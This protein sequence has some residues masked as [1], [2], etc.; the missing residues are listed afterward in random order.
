MKKVFVV[1]DH[2][3]M[4]EMLRALILR[5]PD[6]AF[7]GDAE[8]GSEALTK[9]PASSPDVILVDVSLPGM[10]G[11]EL[12]EQL[13]VKHPELPALVITGHDGAV[14]AEQAFR[15][16]ARGFIMKGDPFAIMTATRGVLNGN[17]Y[18]DGEVRQDIGDPYRSQDEES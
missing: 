6:M 17:Y 14:Y 7:C 1:E 10:S 8:T 2:A 9:I 13:R 5:E 15:A 4:R 16:G 3:V 12:L 18:V 11:I